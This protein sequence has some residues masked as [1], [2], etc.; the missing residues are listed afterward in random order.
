MSSPRVIFGVQPVMEAIRSGRRVD[1]VYIARS[2]GGA[3]ARI[4]N[5]AKKANIPVS[6]VPKEEI[7][8]R[9]SGTSHQGVLASVDPSEFETIDVDRILDL[10]EEAGEPALVV[11]LDG[12]EDPQNLGA[13]IRS[14]YAL[15]AHGVVLPKNRAAGITPAV[16]RASAG[17]T[18]HVP[19]ARVT[20][21]KHALETLARRDVWTAA[22]TLDGTPAAEA[23]LDGALG[24]VIGSESKG[25]KPSLAAACD[26]QITIPLGGDFDSLNASVAAGILL[27][28]ARRQRA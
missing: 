12:I 10:A 9:A 1:R 24:L 26:L 14:A 15:G 19:I 11:L 18:M 7:D 25:V 3:T 16:V 27:Y 4:K 28:E 20:N 22:A 6:Y 23:R 8:R 13:I 17:A 2:S 5:A 21:L